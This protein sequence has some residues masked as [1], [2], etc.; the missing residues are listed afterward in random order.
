MSVTHK[1]LER[2]STSV[3]NQS[4]E[5]LQQVADLVG[6]ALNQFIIRQSPT[7]FLVATSLSLLVGE[8]L[9]G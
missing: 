1:K 8:V 3:T 2:V 5:L 9:Q 7:D 6:S 4:R